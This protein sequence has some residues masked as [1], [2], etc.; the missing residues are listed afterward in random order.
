MRARFKNDIF[1]QTRRATSKGRGEKEGIHCTQSRRIWLVL[2][3]ERTRPYK[4]N[5]VLL[6]SVN[7]NK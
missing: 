5:R 6:L 7:D 2:E 4:V 3:K 1:P